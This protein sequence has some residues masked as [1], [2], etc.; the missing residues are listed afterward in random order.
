M[1]L[2]VDAAGDVYAR[3]LADGIVEDI[4]P[5]VWGWAAPAH[6]VSVE[7]RCSLDE[8]L[9]SRASSFESRRGGPPFRGE[10]PG[11]RVDGMV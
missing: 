2:R 4:D 9:R 3:E 6:H 5:D 7:R 8:L 1:G 10:A 11:R